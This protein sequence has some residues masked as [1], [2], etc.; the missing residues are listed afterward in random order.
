VVAVIILVGEKAELL[1]GCDVFRHVVEV[2]GVRWIQRVSFDGVFEDAW[3]RFDRSHKVR[4][5]GVIKERKDL[6]IRQE[7]PGMDGVGIGEENEGESAIPQIVHGGP[8]GG[9]GSEDAVP[10]LA[11][12]VWSAGEAEA[13]RGPSD[14]RV[15]C[16]LARFEIVLFVDEAEDTFLGVRC[17]GGD[18]SA[19]GRLEIKSQE[20]ISDINE[21]VGGWHG[22]ATIGLIHVK[23][24]QILVA[25]VGSCKT[26]KTHPDS[27]R[28]SGCSGICKPMWRVIP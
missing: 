17:F 24:S 7:S 27:M 21:S 1:T 10:F 26:P 19:K 28:K 22:K 2:E 11:E 3:V 12:L 5:D 20:D 23:D 9:D 6:I 4:K 14:E 15:L 18:E 25:G 13:F 16:D 8:H